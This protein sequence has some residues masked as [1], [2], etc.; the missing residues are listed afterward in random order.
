MAGIVKGLDHI[1]V[2]VEDSRG[3]EWLVK[4][5][6]EELD[7][8]AVDLLKDHRS[9]L[10]KHIPHIKHTVRQQQAIKKERR[11]DYMI[12]RMIFFK[13][14]IKTAGQRMQ[15]EIAKGEL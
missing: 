15:E 6:Q 7:A 1:T 8:I 14:D 9:R 13:E 4:F 11:I 12:G 3:L 2:S 10:R 5:E